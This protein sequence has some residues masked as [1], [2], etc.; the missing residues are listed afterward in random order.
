MFMQ[1]ANNMALAEGK[2]PVVPRSEEEVYRVL[3][4]D[5][6][7]SDIR[8]AMGPLEGE[9]YWSP[10]PGFD[11]PPDDVALQQVTPLLLRDPETGMIYAAPAFAQQGR[12]GINYA[13]YA[14]AQG[15][16]HQGFRED[17]AL[18]GP[19]TAS[20]QQ[21]SE[22]SLLEALARMLRLGKKER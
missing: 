13:D 3:L 9:Q 8:F 5:R 16:A 18:A 14:M 7:L 10:S 6:P 17:I 11:R 2:Q 15:L 20:P 21:Q 22:E 1:G 4:A 19:P 12:G